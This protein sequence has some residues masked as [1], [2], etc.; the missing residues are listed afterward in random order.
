M[1]KII[2][3]PD[4]SWGAIDMGTVQ[5]VFQLIKSDSKKLILCPDQ[6]PHFRHRDRDVSR[7][8]ISPDCH[9]CYAEQRKA[10][11]GTYHPASPP[12]KSGQKML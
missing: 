7:S 3:S 12:H 5:I 2:G 8:G 9:V 1:D 4:V 11:F 6:V 10:G